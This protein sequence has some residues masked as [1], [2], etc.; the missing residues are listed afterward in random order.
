M[1]V[2]RLAQLSLLAVMR[3]IVPGYRIRL[4]TE[5]ELAA[6]VSKDVQRVRTYESTLL[7]LYQVRRV[8]GSHQSIADPDWQMSP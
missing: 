1:Q 3:D 8:A 7:Q 2:R 4:P 6:P 5:K